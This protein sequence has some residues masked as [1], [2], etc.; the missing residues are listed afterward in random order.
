MTLPPQPANDTSAE[1]ASNASFVRQLTQR[2]ED[3]RRRFV[4]ELH[5]SIGAALV[6]ARLKALAIEEPARDGTIQL[7]EVARLARELVGQLSD[8]YAA[9]RGLVKRL[10]PETLDVFG[11]RAAL[12]E[13]VRSYDALDNKCEFVFVGEGIPKIKGELAS[14]GYRLVQEAL[15]NAVKY[16]QATSVCVIAR[17]DAGHLQ[18]RVRDDGV[19]FDPTEHSQGIGLHHMRERV[20]CIG[21]RMAIFSS[22]EEG[23]TVLFSLPLPTD[24]ETSRAPDRPVHEGR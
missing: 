7:D 21:G 9:T 5:D 15:T 23:T 10:R 14:H 11:L 24:G 16:S 4:G 18:L 20:A 1:H 3:E 19:G 8:V 2:V 13:L 17:C 22:E 6:A 12:A